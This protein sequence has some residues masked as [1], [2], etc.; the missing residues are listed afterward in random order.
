MLRWAV[1]IQIMIRTVHG[2]IQVT[3]IPEI[4]GITAILFVQDMIFV[5]LK[6]QRSLRL[7]NARILLTE[8]NAGFQKRLLIF[9]NI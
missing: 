2:A 4:I 7:T 3:Q 1:Q 8:F 5:A 9:F 6:P